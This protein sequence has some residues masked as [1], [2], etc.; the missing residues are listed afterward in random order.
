MGHNGQKQGTM[1]HNRIKQDQNGS[2]WCP[3]LEDLEPFVSKKCVLGPFQTIWMP[4]Q[5]ISS[6]I[7]K[8]IF[9]D[10]LTILGYFGPFG[11]LFG[12]FLGPFWTLKWPQEP[13]KTAGNLPELGKRGQKAI[14]MCFGTVLDHLDAILV[15]FE[16]NLKIEKISTFCHRVQ[17][18][19]VVP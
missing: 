18:K 9:F 2:G 16:Q 1:G 10:F 19:F 15:H 6:R 3:G 12:P 7:Q 4:F 5:C 11:A 14:Q 8:S 17:L 13:Q